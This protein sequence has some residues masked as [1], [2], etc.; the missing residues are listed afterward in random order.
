M[1]IKRYKIGPG[2][3]SE[4]TIEQYNEIKD[5][6]LNKNQ[7]KSSLFR[8]YHRLYNIDKHTFKA[9]LNEI[10]MEDLHP[11]CSVLHHSKTNKSMFSSTKNQYMIGYNSHQFYKN[12]PK[13]DII[14]RQHNN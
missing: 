6:Y 3:S 7:A 4:V 13:T 12:P 8:K 9:I 5:S 14:P 11:S 2:T 1:T 10:Y